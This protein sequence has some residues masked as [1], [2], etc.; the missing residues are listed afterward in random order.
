MAGG[1]LTP[2]QKMINLMYL[3]FIAMLAMNMSKEVLSAFGLMNEKFESANAA[4]TQNNQAL[5]MSLDTKAAEA[6]GNF[7]AAAATA[8][9]VEVITKE[10]DAYIAT[11]KSDVL[12]GFTVDAETGKLPYENMDKGDNI[13]NWFVGEGYTKKGEEIIAKIENYKA[14]MKAA[15]GS[16]KKFASIIGEVQ[17][18]FNIGEVTDKDGNKIKYLN[19]HF[20][21]FPA[22]ASVA[23]LSAWQNDVKKAEADV[24]NSALGK[25]AVEAAS[26]SNYQAIVVLEKNAYFQGEN[27]KGKVVLGRYDE[28]TKPTSFQGPGRLENGQAVISLTAGGV[29]EQ[30]INGQFSFLEDGKT[31]PLKFAGKY[32]VVPRPN[33][34]TISADKMN[35]VYRGVVNPMSISF[36]G[37]SDKDVVA[38]APGLTKVGN[39]KYNM[40]PG[41]GSEVVINVSGKMSDGKVASDKRVYR[42]KGIPGPSG[43]IRGEM[44]VVKGPK[45]NLQVATIGAKLVDFDFEVG[46][47]VVGFNFKIAGQP[48]VQVSGNRLNAQC[49]SALSKAGRGDQVTISEIKTKLVGAGSYLLP[50]TAP[51][52]FEIQ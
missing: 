33:S 44:G 16:D 24:Y 23:K 39:G 12:K 43:T 7:I 48:T 31:I 30:N 37:I 10:F 15:L 11:L 49:V 8:H 22:V 47:D 13:D 45:S 41:S 29:G 35:V 32:V 50:R 51:V 40:S 25:A 26:Y 46:L 38:T 52:I 27:V 42:I 21:G 19:Y 20:K 14:D 3:V 2:R 34:A 18:K 9:K 17:D 36:A 6:K 28:N 4:S 5:L 1:K